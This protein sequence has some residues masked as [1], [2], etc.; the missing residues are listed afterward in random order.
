MAKG[1]FVQSFVLQD[2]LAVHVDPADLPSVHAHVG[3]CDRS[4]LAVFEEV[5]GR[6]TCRMLKSFEGT[7][8]AEQEAELRRLLGELPVARLSIDR[9]GIGM[10]LAR[11]RPQGDAA[12]PVR[13][14]PRGATAGR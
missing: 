11:R 8:F 2:E 6:F 12:D 5:E 10:N 9:N 13:L 7:P 14:P 1:C 4:E 3:V